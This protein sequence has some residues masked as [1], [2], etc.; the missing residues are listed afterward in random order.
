MSRDWNVIETVFVARNFRTLGYSADS[1]MI[2][3]HAV[4]AVFQIEIKG[5]YVV[6]YYFYITLSFLPWIVALY[7]C[8][9]VS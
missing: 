3:L 4:V 7:S 5:N 6:R 2:K 1:Q 9:V 8:V